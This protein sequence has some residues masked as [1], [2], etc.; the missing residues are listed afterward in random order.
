MQFGRNLDVGTSAGCMAPDSA[1]V[2]VARVKDSL[3]ETPLRSLDS[4]QKQLPNP[5]IFG[6]QNPDIL[7]RNWHGGASP[8]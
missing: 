1:D 4:F 6:G 3:P 5:D 7:D 2:A 8:P